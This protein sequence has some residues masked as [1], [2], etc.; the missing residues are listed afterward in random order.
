MGCMSPWDA[1]FDGL[2]VEVIQLLRGTWK[3]VVAIGL[4][5]GGS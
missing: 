4:E 5:G 3:K 1:C 2:A